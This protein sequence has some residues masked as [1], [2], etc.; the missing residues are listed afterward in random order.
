MGDIVVKRLDEDTID[1]QIYV[2]REA[3]GHTEDLADIKKRWTVKHYQNPAG[4]SYVFG[5]Y[6]GEEL[7]GINCFLPVKYSFN[8]ETVYA[9][10][11]CESGVLHSHRGMGIWS[12]IVRFAELYL[13]DENKVRFIIG[14]PNYTTSYPGF[15]KMGWKTVSDMKNLVLINNGKTFS[16]TVLHG[17][18]G[19][20][21]A[22]VLG[23]Q[24]TKVKCAS[25]KMKCAV[26]RDIDTF[27]HITEMLNAPSADTFALVYSPE[28]LYWKSRYAKLRAFEVVTGDTVIARCFYSP[29]NYSS[30]PIV[31]V[32]AIDTA[33]CDDKEKRG[34]Y[35]ACISYLCKK[36]PETAFVRAWLTENNW[37]FGL[38]RKLGFLRSKHP[39]PFIVSNLSDDARC[40]Q[41]ESWKLSFMDLDYS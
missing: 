2:Y 13:K 4:N 7:V 15:V 22:R 16:K 35:A 11:S 25:K 12:K 17:D 3:F 6:D 40:D 20:G 33:S 26:M 29:T 10:Q 21:I 37:E 36:Y 34:I 19:I 38:F 18:R 9:V 23:I 8:R 14:F 27:D 31:K 5:A 32:L 28:F 1:D 41:T 39:N 24:K 30:V